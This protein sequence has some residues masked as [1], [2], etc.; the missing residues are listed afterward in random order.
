MSGE[1]P[2]IFVRMWGNDL[3]IDC[4]AALWCKC[5]KHRGYFSSY[6]LFVLQ[7]D[8]GSPVWP[9][10]G[11][12]VLSASSQQALWINNTNTV[13]WMMTSSNYNGWLHQWTCNRQAAIFDYW[14]KWIPTLFY[15]TGWIFNWISRKNGWKCLS[16]LCTIQ[17]ELSVKGHLCCGRSHLKAVIEVEYSLKYLNMVADCFPLKPPFS[18]GARLWRL[19]YECYVLHAFMFCVNKWHL[20]IL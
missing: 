15:D 12:W 2:D 13:T 10:C 14:G 16:A 9:F 1:H 11:P 4:F 18:K 17:I 19:T 8:L 20:F 3:N 5:F 6:P 7:P